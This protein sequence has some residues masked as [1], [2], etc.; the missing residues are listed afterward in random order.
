VKCT[1]CGGYN[2]L[3]LDGKL[4][5]IAKYRTNESCDYI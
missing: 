2:V 3:C 5:G 1:F 4:I